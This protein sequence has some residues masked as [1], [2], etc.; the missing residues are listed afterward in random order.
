MI[1]K[2]R[3]QLLRRPNTVMGCIFS[4]AGFT[5]SSVTNDPITPPSD[6]KKAIRSHFWS[7]SERRRSVSQLINEHL[8]LATMLFEASEIQY[9]NLKALNLVYPPPCIREPNESLTGTTSSAALLVCAVPAH[10]DSEFLVSGI[11]RF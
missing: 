7:A 4:P 9:P 5:T 8:A 6:L 1:A 3:Y 11:L 2:V 10:P